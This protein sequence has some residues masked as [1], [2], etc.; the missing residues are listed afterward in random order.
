MRTLLFLIFLFPLLTSA[1]INRSAN[2]LAQETT[3]NYIQKKLFKGQ[4]YT[5]IS[6]GE[7]KSYKDKRDI[8]IEWMIEHR[9]EISK[10]PGST[11]K[12]S[13][14]TNQPYKFIFFLDHQMKVKRAESYHVTS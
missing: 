8:E 7:I 9:F 11:D 13:E 3:R 14:E 4:T 10:P 12:K 6:Y 2:E 5:P 1:Q